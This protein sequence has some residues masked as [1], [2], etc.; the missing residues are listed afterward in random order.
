MAKYDNCSFCGGV[1]AERFIQK[2]CF[3]GDKLVAVVDDVPTGV[4][5]QCGEKY[6]KASVLKHIEN[7][8]KKRRRLKQIKVPLIEY[9]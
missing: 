8:L 4:C 3:W 6:Y 5:G 9:V 7:E 2:P 1:V